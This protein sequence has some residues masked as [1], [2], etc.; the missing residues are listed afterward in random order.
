V[1]GDPGLV[2]YGPDGHAAWVAALEIA[3]GVVVAARSALNLDELVHVA[4]L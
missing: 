2:F 1:N 3:G 4:P